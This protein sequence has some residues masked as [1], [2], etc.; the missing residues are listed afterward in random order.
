[1]CRDT[2]EYIASWHFKWLYTHSSLQLY[3][4]IYSLV[5]QRFTNSYRFFPQKGLTFDPLRYLL[6]IKVY[7]DISLRQ[8]LFFIRESNF[9]IFSSRAKF[10]AIQ[11]NHYYVKQNRF[12]NWLSK[13][14]KIKEEKEK[15]SNLSSYFLLAY[16]TI[17]R[18]SYF[19][20][21]IS[22]PLL[23]IWK[24]INHLI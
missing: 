17:D 11:F 16:I 20:L 23:Y 2:S 22:F 13:I 15:D 12:V 5:L 7:W 18:P 14:K 6:K 19:Y 21:W 24:L 4:Y 9:N 10:H 8:F 3:T 1:M